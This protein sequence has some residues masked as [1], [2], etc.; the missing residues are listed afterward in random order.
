MIYQQDEQFPKAVHLYGCYLLAL[1]ERFT[2]ALDEPFT[3]EFVLDVLGYG[4][5]NRLIDEEITLLNPQALCDY[6][7]GVGRYRFLGKFSPSYYAAD[8]EFEV[9]CYHKDGASFNHFCSGNGKGIVL[10]DPWSVDGSD[11][12]RNGILIGKRIYRRM[13]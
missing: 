11:S 10:Y 2:T 5:K 6:M 9:V 1:C 8:N 4:Q 13:A 3:H 7:T 12:V